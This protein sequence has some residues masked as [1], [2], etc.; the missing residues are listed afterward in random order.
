LLEESVEQLAAVARGSTIK[1]EGIFIEVI[2]QMLMG[3]SSL[4][5][6]EQ[7][8]LQQSC[9]PATQ[10]QEVVPD[11][12]ILTCYFMNIA[13]PFQPI[14]SVPVIG[15]HYTA[16]FHNSPN[17]RTQAPCRG[18]PDALKAD[19]TDM[20]PILLCCYDYQ[21]FPLRSTASFPRFLA[22]NIGLINLDCA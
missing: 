2:I 1:S 12:T 8:S 21:R 13:K 7:P 3:H 15:L 18:V 10:R 6:S 17:C 4:M 5:G 16:R 14:V 22:T 9:Y 11:G 20:L 19:S